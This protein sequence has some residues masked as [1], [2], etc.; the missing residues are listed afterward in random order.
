MTRYCL[1][2]TVMLS[3]TTYNDSSGTF[4]LSGSIRRQLLSI[5]CSSIIG[6]FVSLIT[7]PE[8]G[9]LMFIA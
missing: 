9:M 6:G 3:L 8:N 1:T 7:V 2:S 5:R 4:N